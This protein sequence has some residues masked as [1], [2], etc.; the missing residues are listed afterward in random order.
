[1]SNSTAVEESVRYIYI[2]SIVSAIAMSISVDY[3]LLGLWLWGEANLL[4]L[5]MTP[6]VIFM[7]SVTAITMGTLI[8]QF[9]NGFM[10]LPG[11]A[12]ALVIIYILGL[13]LAL[14]YFAY[15]SIIH[16]LGLSL[17]IIDQDLVGDHYLG[18]GLALY[19]TGLLMLTWQIGEDLL[20]GKTSSLYR[21]LM[22]MFKDIDED[23]D[24]TIVVK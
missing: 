8:K 17:L 24:G 22:N 4:A 20:G 3:I 6:V 1:M 7:I 11:R 18:L 23:N 19:N 12:R 14:V 21:F 16:Y 9:R 10:K 15:T 13:L 5:V 2:T